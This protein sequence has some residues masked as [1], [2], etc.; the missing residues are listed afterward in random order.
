MNLIRILLEVGG[1]SDPSVGV[2]GIGR[3]SFREQVGLIRIPLGSSGIGVFS[4][5]VTG[6]SQN[7]FSNTQ[8]W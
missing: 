7:S 6:I 5:G 1:N 2:I 8:D 4:V 3:N